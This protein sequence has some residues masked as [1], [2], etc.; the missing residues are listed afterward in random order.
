[1]YT[2]FVSILCSHI[3][4]PFCIPILY[5]KYV[6]GRFC[7]C[8]AIIVVIVLLLWIKVLRVWLSHPFHLLPLLSPEQ[9]TIRRQARLR[10]HSRL[11]LLHCRRRCR[12]P[13]RLQKLILVCNINICIHDRFHDVFFIC[14]HGTFHDLSKNI[15]ESVVNTYGKT[16]WKVSGIHMKKHLENC[17]EYI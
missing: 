16:S 10:R 11:R 15:V 7:R 5:T 12:S 6:P 1:M 4:N 3:V 8:S 13:S 14:I 9:G 17:R 2:H